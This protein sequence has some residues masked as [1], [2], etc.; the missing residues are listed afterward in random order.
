MGRGKLAFRSALTAADDGDIPRAVHQ[1]RRLISFLGE[2]D[3]DDPV[4]FCR[5]SE[6]LA[7]FLL[8]IDEDAQAIAAAEAAVDALPEEPPR[9]ERAR[10]LATHARALPAMEDEA[11]AR[12]RAEQALA[13][14]RAASAPRVEADSLVTLGQLSERAW[15]IEDARGL[16]PRPLQHARRA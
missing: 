16:F 14:A 3:S 1:L 5:A 9:W 8:D 10:A 12:S 13:A 2:G 6:R 11:P 7:Y 15:P 4:L